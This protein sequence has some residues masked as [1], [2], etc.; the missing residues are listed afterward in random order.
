MHAVPLFSF[1]NRKEKQKEEESNRVMGGRG[2]ERGRGI[3]EG[4]GGILGWGIPPSMGYPRDF[5]LVLWFEL[6]MFTS[7]GSTYSQKDISHVITLA[8]LSACPSSE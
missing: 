8:P 3:G 4:V 7:I 6:A 2:G 1:I 5:L